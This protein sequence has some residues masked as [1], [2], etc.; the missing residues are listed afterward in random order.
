MVIHPVT[1]LLVP[2]QPVHST[3]IRSSASQPMPALPAPKTP[4]QKSPLF[5]PINVDTFL[6]SCTVFSPPP[7]GRQPGSLTISGPAPHLPGRQAMC[8][9]RNCNVPCSYGK[10]Q[11]IAP[12]SPPSVTGK[13]KAG[14][15]LDY[16][17][18]V[19]QQKRDTR[20][21]QDGNGMVARGN[22]EEEQQAS[23]PDESGSGGGK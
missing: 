14:L 3:C 20:R 15:A 12:P 23:Q 9:R 7:I 6:F 21:Q 10:K 16:T 8:R 17:Y 2:Q 22:K 18:I 11:K 1:C 4:K 19:M 5:V 13:G